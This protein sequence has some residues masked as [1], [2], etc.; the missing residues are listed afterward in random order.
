MKE[1]KNIYFQP[2]FFIIS[3]IILNTIP[4]LNGYHYSLQLNL[5][6]YIIENNYDIKIDGIYICQFHPFINNYQMIE[7]NLDILFLKY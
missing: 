5:Y 1:V 7:A 3:G 6:K 2:D 4:N